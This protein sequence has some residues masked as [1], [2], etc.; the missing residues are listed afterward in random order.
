MKSMHRVIMA[1]NH[2]Q[3]VAATEDER[4]FV[5]CDV[6]D[7]KRGDDAYFA[8]LVKMVKGQ[9]EATLAA[10]M[11]HLQTR[12]ISNFNPERAARNAGG[13]DLARQKLLGLDPPLQ[14]LLEVALADPTSSACHGLLHD[15]GPPGAA[16]IHLDKTISAWLKDRATS[17]Q[18]AGLEWPK[19]EALAGYRMWMKRAQARGASEFTGAEV[20]WNSL[21]RL[22]NKKIFPGRKLFRTSGGKRFVCLPPRAELVDGFNRLLGA[23][24][25]DVEEDGC[26]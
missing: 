6:S 22:L 17:S 8:P 3:V 2:D 9:D 10:F 26:D 5:V 14:W 24:V 25:V 1:S 21:K 18:P 11:H 20:F 13:R 7:D 19:A 16:D 12:D 15:V 23:K 4:R